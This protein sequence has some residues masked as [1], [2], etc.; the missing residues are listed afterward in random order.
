MGFE[1][2]AIVEIMGHVRLAG[3]VTEETIAG[4]QLLRVDVPK[5]K[6]R[7]PFTKYY[8]ATA[9]YSITPTDEATA[10]FAAEQFDQQPVQPYVLRM[11]QNPALA[12]KVIDEDEYDERYSD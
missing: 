3:K 5:T 9:I 10:T 7:E 1:A 12:E 8:G 4:V 11:P 2:W 6:T